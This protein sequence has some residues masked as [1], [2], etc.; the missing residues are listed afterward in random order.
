MKSCLF[1]A[2]SAEFAFNGTAQRLGGRFKKLAGR[3]VILFCW[4]ELVR[5]QWR[6]T[7]LAIPL[8]QAAVPAVRSTFKVCVRETSSHA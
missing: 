6:G 4:Q 3:G 5:H 1:F 2:H 7:V 8:T